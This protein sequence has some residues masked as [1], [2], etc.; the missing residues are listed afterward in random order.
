MKI[1][2]LVIEDNPTREVTSSRLFEKS[3]VQRN[4]EFVFDENGIFSYK[5]FPR[6][7]DHKLNT[8]YGYIDIGEL[9]LPRYSLTN[10]S[11]LF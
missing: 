1:K 9:C 8:D 11:E 2:R 7:V 3:V 10:K 6:Y 4:G 5:I